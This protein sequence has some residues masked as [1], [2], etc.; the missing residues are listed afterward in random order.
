MSNIIGLTVYEM[1][2]KK[3]FSEWWTDAMYRY[4]VCA[5]TKTEYVL[6][7]MNSELEKHGATCNFVYTPSTTDILPGSISGLEVTFDNEESMTLF[8]LK[9]E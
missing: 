8:L 5:L 4:N 7:C 6:K 1:R 2:T 3:P 9:Y